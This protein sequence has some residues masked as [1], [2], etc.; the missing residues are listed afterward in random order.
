MNKQPDPYIRSLISGIPLY[1]SSAFDYYDAL[2]TLPDKKFDAE[3]KD[4]IYYLL[5]LLVV[6]IAVVLILYYDTDDVI[7]PLGK[8]PITTNNKIPSTNH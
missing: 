4:Y 8:V 3:K 2:D 1:D 5:I 7:L 6:I